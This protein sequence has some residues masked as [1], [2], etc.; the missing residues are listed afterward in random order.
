MFHA[1]RV[2][3]K[4]RK[5]S[6]HDSP[7]FPCRYLRRQVVVYMCHNRDKIWKHKQASLRSKYG[8]DDDDSPPISY[9]Q[10]LIKM[11]KRSTWGEDVVL[12]ALSC[13]FWVKITVINAGRETLDE[14]RYR[15]RLPMAT[16]DMVLIYNGNNDYSFAGE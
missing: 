10:Y 1:F 3:C 9:R 4:L 12:H 6:D 11:L 7:Y 14:S 2:V 5:F 16:A 13:L 8:L 15:H